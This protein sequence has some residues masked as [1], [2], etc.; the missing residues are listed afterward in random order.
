[1]AIW[2]RQAQ[3]FTAVHTAKAGHAGACAVLAL[4]CVFRREAVVRAA[5]AVARLALVSCVANTGAVAVARPVCRAVVRA[6]F[7]A[8]V[9]L[10]EAVVTVTHSVVSARATTRAVLGTR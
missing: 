3:H 2:V 1:M 7:E 8:A 5:F 4:P 6:E 9:C 10:G